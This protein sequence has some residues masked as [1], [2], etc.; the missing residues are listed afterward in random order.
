MNL[1]SAG[2][3]AGKRRS[4]QIGKLRLDLGIGKARVDLQVKLGDDLSGCI[5]GGAKEQ[6]SR[7]SRSP[8]EIT[9]R[10]NFGQDLERVAVVTARARNLPA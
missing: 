6:P 1:P 4:G 9:Y 2:G 10:C 7:S 8:H 3:R 5:L